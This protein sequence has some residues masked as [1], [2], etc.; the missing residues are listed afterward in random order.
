MGSSEKIE[1]VHCHSKV[2]KK[3]MKYMR[4]SA[5]REAE[6]WKLITRLQHENEQ[7]RKE[8]ADLKKKHGDKKHRYVCPTDVNYEFKKYCKKHNINLNLD[9]KAKRIRFNYKLKPRT[10][11][12]IDFKLKF[13][14]ALIRD[15][16]EKLVQEVKSRLGWIINPKNLPKQTIDVVYRNGEFDT[17]YNDSHLDY[18]MD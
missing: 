18:L 5:E 2:A 15:R 17:D 12:R 4:Q 16:E 11:R 7:L 1:C 6:K 9:M 14:P 10:Y 8:V 3:N 13:N